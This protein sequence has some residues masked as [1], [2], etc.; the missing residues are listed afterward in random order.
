MNAK[1][2]TLF[3]LLVL[4]A[5]PFVFS[6][7]NKEYKGTWTFM[8]YMEA[9]ND[10]EI[11]A[12]R[13]MRQMQQVGSNENI[14]IVA[15]HNSYEK[16][17]YCSKTFL[18]GKGSKATLKEQFSVIDKG[19]ENLINFCCDTIKTFPADHYALI[20]WNHGTGPLE[21]V[22]RSSLS[23]T[24]IFSLNNPSDFFE[25]DNR[26]F[27]AFQTLQKTIVQQ[28]YKGICFNDSSGKFLTEK[29][30][31]RALKTIC[32]TSLKNKK[33]DL[34][35]FDACLMSTVE[36]AKAVEPYAKI[37]VASQD[38]ERGAGW[39]YYYALF[40]FTFTSLLPED[41]GKHI[42]NA[43]KKTYQKIADFTLSCLILEKIQE[44]TE[45]ISHVGFLLQK[46]LITPEA[47]KGKLLI[48]LSRN[49]HLCTYFDEPDLIDLHH[50]YHN[51]FTNL[52]QTNAL[53]QQEKEDLE[54]LK[55]EILKGEYLI[56]NIVY[57]NT[58]G[59]AY[60]HAKGISIYFP[61]HAIHSSYRKNCFASQTH[62]LPFLK[63]YLSAYKK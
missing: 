44:L 54:L 51:L 23:S 17:Q 62:W 26:G 25:K 53:E 59:S 57:A 39:N 11:F 41:F 4:F 42:V 36:I 7:E 13:N 15:Q 3:L 12:P 45:N 38:V 35:G 6:N 2:A 61:E 30:L 48:K 5:T 49:K 52:E 29:H 10:L 27:I 19:E 40:P 60:P 9:A 28:K 16:N 31:C 22:L 18:I 24:D 58:V 21:P 20:L 50:F 33:L 55:K 43:Y 32:A 56:E 47:K 46:I 63:T 8:V 37:M 34:L 14:T 1:K